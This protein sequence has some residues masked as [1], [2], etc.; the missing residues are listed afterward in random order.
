M[1]SEAKHLG[2]KGQA[3]H[4]RPFTRQVGIQGD[5]AK[6]LCKGGDDLHNRFESNT[7]HDNTR[8]KGDTRYRLK[9][10]AVSSKTLDNVYE[11]VVAGRL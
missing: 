9:R 11:R 10:E 3:H 6:T 8:F 4:P 5:N 1:L 2:K 7:I